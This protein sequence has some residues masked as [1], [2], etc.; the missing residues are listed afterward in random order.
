M[1]P[2]SLIQAALPP[3]PESPHFRRAIAA[4]QLVPLLPSLLQINDSLIVL[5]L[6]LTKVGSFAPHR[7]ERAKERHRGI[8]REVRANEPSD[9]KHLF[10]L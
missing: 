3:A 1:V 4:Q 2:P 8:P 7:G 9:Y 5:Y 6:A 10:C